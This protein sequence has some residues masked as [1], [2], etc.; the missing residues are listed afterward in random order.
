MKIT[1]YHED[2]NNRTVLE[3]PDEECNIMVEADYHRRLNAAADK[4][5]VKY[6][7]PQEIM[8][9]DFNKPN[10]NNHHS[11]TRRHAS[12]DALVALEESGNQA[13][14]LDIPTDE[15][16]DLHRALAKLEPRQRELLRKIFWEG[17]KQREI[18]D[19][20]GVHEVAVSRRLARIY[21]RLKKIL[22][23]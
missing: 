4:S 1:L 8:D 11:E 20:E 15:Y 16:V 14:S 7:T 21:A 3:V 19:D 5:V 12:L 6:R 10:F 2:K 9:E 22:K 18:A 13:A 17:M 23:T